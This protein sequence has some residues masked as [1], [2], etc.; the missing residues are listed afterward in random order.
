[1]DDTKKKRLEGAVMA[2]ARGGMPAAP[3]GAGA[4]VRASSAGQPTEP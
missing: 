3:S 2:A 1:M 4:K